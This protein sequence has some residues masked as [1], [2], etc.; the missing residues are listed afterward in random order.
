MGETK[1]TYTTLLADPNIHPKYEE[2]LEEVEKEFLAKRWPMH[3]GG[4]ERF[5]GKEFEKRSPIDRDILVGRFQRGSR[6]DLKEAIAAAKEAFDEWKRTDWK[7]RVRIFRKVADLL[8]MERFRL[9]AII[10]YEVGKNR[11]EALAEVH[12]AIDAIRYYADLMEAENGYIKRMAPGAPGEETWSIAVPYGVWAVISPFN[13][14]LMLANGMM[15]GALLTGNT[16]VWKPTSEAPLTAIQLY[17]VYVEGGVP[18]GVLNLVTGPGG[19]FE[20][21]I[22]SNPDVAGI[23]FTGSR[24]VGMRLYR[25]FTSE[26][27]YPKPIVLE[28]GSKNPTIVTAKADM[29]KAVEGVIRAA[30]GYDGQKCSATSRLYVEESIAEEFLERLVERTGQLV[31]GDP[32]RREVFMGPV[33]NERAYNNF[34]KYVEDAV[35]AGGKILHGGKTLTEGPLAK[36]FYVEPTIISGVPEGHY[37]WKEELFVPIL[38]VDTFKTLEEA[39]SKANDTDYGLTAGIFSEDEEEVKYFFEHIDF[40]VT[41]ANRRGGATTGAWPGAQTFVGWKASGATGRGVGGP[42]YLLNY[43]REQAR[44]IV[45]EEKR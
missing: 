41:Y 11:L 1:I 30:F 13:F 8:E 40:G 5:T 15:L 25:R 18:E 10:T 24:E 35:K 31:I 14:P 27:P 44:T 7:E 36:G 42:Y 16:V 45:R 20:D 43:F 4:K 33:I 12:E 2:A 34:K 37:L 23:A 26:Q 9:A 28:M 39:L 38:L 22:V 21:E 32:R 17:R 19:E 6:G 29:D 3:V